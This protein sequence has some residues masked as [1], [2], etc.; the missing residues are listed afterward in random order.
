MGRFEHR[1]RTGN[2]I[3]PPLCS[4]LPGNRRLFLRCS[5]FF[6]TWNGTG[7]SFCR[8]R[9]PGEIKN[10]NFRVP[11][12]LR[13]KF[14]PGYRPGWQKKGWTL[15]FGGNSGK[16]P[17]IGDVIAENLSKNDVIQLVKSSLAYYL[18]NA[19]KKERTAKF[20]NRVGV[21]EFKKAVL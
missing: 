1:C 14:C 20:M 21:D 15:I 6:G 10:R 17:R 2:G 19:K 5:G 18:E 7:A 4:G 8:K 12:L 9:T 16:K 13:R 11:V 3:M